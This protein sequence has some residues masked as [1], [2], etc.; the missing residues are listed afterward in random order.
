[1]EHQ[2]TFL[3]RNPSWHFR[4]ILIS[5]LGF[6]ALDLAIK[7]YGSNF[8]INI[9]AYNY[10]HTLR[11]NVIS[12]IAIIICLL[13]DKKVIIPTFGI[14]CLWLFFQKQHRAAI[15][16]FLTVASAVIT[17][18]L[19]KILVASSRPGDMTLALENFSFPSGHVTLICAYLI[20]LYALI[21]PAFHHSKQRLMAIG[22]IVLIVAEIF[23]RLLL[24]A[25]WVTDI[26]AGIL[27][28]TSCGLLGIY[29]YYR[30]FEPINN[31]KQLIAVVL[32]A[33]F[34]CSCIYMILFYKKMLNQYQ[35][36]N[37]VI[38]GSIHRKI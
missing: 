1:M 16:C 37:G 28:G 29:G 4:F 13:G 8:L 31:D 2:D 27:L 20:F 10:F 38:G 30:K 33:F 25:H 6:I 23:A 15:Y 32:L 5:F 22:F 19:F 9:E 36:E 21:A 7:W 24:D 11:T 34:I 14:I 17:T 26:L 3:K 18:Y 12:N 35:I